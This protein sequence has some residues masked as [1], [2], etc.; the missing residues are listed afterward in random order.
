MASWP[1]QYMVGGGST[2]FCSHASTLEWLNGNGWTTSRRE[3]IF[4][5]YTNQNGEAILK[6]MPPG[7]EQVVAGSKRWKSKQEDVTVNITAGATESIIMEM[8]LEP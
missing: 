2:I 1:N 7:K 3:E 6:N 5:A 8:E 4:T